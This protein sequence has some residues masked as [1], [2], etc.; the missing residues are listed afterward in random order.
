MLSTAGV[1]AGLLLVSVHIVYG[2]GGSRVIVSI[3]SHCVGRG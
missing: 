3:S 2:G 1:V